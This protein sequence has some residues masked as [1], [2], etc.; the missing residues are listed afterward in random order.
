[1]SAGAGAGAPLEVV[2]VAYGPPDTLAGAL[3]ALE[4]AFAV[5]VVDNGSSPA[6][7]AVAEA[8]GAD[9]VDPGANLGFAAAVNLALAHRHRPGG[10]VLLLNP[11]ARIDP[12][13]LRGLQAEL[14]ARPRAACAAP[15]LR[16]SGSGGPSPNRWPWHTPAGAWAEAVGLAR[17]RTRSPRYFLGGAVL[18]LR[19]EALAEVGQ[20]DERFFLYGEDEDW[21]HRAV[22]RGWELHQAGGLV[23]E[24]AAGGT[25]R[26]P[27]RH[28]LRLH[29]AVERYVRKWYGGRGWA[30]YRAGTVLGLAARA[31]LAGAARRPATVAL[32]RLYLGSPDGAA[33]RA[34]AVPADGARPRPR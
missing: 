31:A 1:V 17:R 6:T 19:G 30:L 7:A 29:S 23:A 2:V 25:D 24:H 12:A 13:T 27:V 28:R 11:D 21:Q 4:G 16:G 8:A 9:Y 26:D 10:D 14:R 34:G 32:L 3:D 20:L 22:R 33:V 15:V 5:T 18:V